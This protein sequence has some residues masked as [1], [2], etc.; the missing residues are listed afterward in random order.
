MIV[1][2]ELRKTIHCCVTHLIVM[3]GVQ[4]PGEARDFPLFRS[5]QADPRAH[6]ITQGALPRE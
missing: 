6:P 4:L 1:N 2:H 3:A 5:V